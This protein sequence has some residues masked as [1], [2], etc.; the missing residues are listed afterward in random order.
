MLI[1]LPELNLKVQRY[2]KKK[3][4]V[5]IENKVDKQLYNHLVLLIRVNI[6]I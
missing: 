6:S 5:S 2:L 1:Y 3:G 4:K